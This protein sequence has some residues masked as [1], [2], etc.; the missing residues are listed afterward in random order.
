M[1]PDS[2]D[3]GKVKIFP[4]NHH[5]LVVSIYTDDEIT[6][7]DI[8]RIRDYFDQFNKRLCLLIKRD[9][10]YSLS[11]AIQA[12]LMEE[13]GQRFEAVAY[14]DHNYLQRDLTELARKTYM[15]DVKVMS[16]SDEK[17]AIEWLEGFSVIS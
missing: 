7:D 15:K 1:Q 5:Y 16:F 9:G 13:A 17:D 2:L 4:G 14:V 11:P 10:H 3:T 8:G 6:A 12:A